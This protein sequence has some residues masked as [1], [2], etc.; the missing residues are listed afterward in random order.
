MKTIWIDLDNTPHIPFFRPIIAELNERGYL[1][2]LTARDAYQVCDLADYFHL[3]YQR[4][5]RHYG[6]SKIM[7]VFGSLVRGLQ[8]VPPMLF[9][10]PDLAVSHGS[11]TQLIAA[12]I[13]G[14]PTVMIYDYEH[15][16]GLVSVHPTWVMVPDIIPDSA[17]AQ[18]STRVYKY[19]GIKE[20]VYVPGFTPDYSTINELGISKEALVVTIR[21]PATEAHY[22]NHK[23]EELFEALVTYLISKPDVQIIVL[24]RNGKQELFIKE[25]WPELFAAKKLIIPDSAIDGLNLMWFSDLVVSGGGTMNREAAAMGVPVY[26][27]FRGKIGAVDRYLSD[28]GRLVLLEN[29]EDFA[30]KIILSRRSKELKA[31]PKANVTLQ[32]I[33]D[34]IVEAVETAK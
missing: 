22:H 17:I 25:M 6:K 3:K 5:G 31:Q 8:L 33:V 24:P 2:R 26:S 11:R 30:N 28:C 13:M 21:P 12:T 16:K 18:N 7:K 4:I 27:I 15:A 23:S 20:D 34:K 14:I 1:V 10:K 19:P 9:N 32:G 29:I